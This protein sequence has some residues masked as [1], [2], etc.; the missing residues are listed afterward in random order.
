MTQKERQERSR[1]MI[2][3]A[4]LQEFG[5]YGYDGVNMEG[6]CGRHGISKGMMYHYFSR[7][8]DLFLLCVDRTFRDLQA[9][10]EETASGQE[11]GNT[12]DALRKYFMIREDYF[13]L[14][15]RQKRVFEN[16]MLRPPRHLTEQIRQLHAPLREMYR[17]F[18]EKL[19]SG[20]PLRPGLK[21]EKAACYLE[22]IGGFFQNAMQT[23]LEKETDH[24]LHA[25]LENAGELLDMVFFGVFRQ[26]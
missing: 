26:Q 20:I 1:E 23:Y 8:D 11:E 5:T 4:A 22:S 19:L 24:D 17:Q 15:P 7:K 18:M 6:I 10:I 16:A 2:Y 25:M 12:L 9:Y 14:H 13:Q 21:P 3:Q